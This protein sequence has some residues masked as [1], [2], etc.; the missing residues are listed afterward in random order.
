MQIS[1]THHNFE[2][3]EAIKN[4]INE[5]LGQTEKHLKANQNAVINLNV[6][7][8]KLSA[9]HKHGNY[10]ELKCYFRYDDINIH[11]ESINSD[12]YAC[13]DEMKD[14]LQ[15]KIAN[16]GDRDRNIMKKIARKFKEF[17]KRSN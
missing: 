16:F 1:I 10:Y 9:H 2:L 5:K 3:T 12:V 8:G 6:D 7:L 14:K 13:I 4:Y 15:Y 11:L 17:I